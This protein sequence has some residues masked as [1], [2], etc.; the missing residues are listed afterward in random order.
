MK[1]YCEVEKDFRDLFRHE[2]IKS[3]DVFKKQFSTT[4]ISEINLATKA[5]ILSSSEFYQS[6]PFF[7]DGFSLSVS[8][9]NLISLRI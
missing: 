8:E 9:A 6:I 7:Y 2:I 1:G 3:A 4:F 5:E